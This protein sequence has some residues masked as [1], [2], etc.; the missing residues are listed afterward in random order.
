MGTRYFRQGFLAAVALILSTGC[1]STAE[2]TQVRVTSA[3]PT[4]VQALTIKVE[5]LVPDVEGEQATLLA[6]LRNELKAMGYQVDSGEIVLTATITGLD[7]GSTIANVVVGLGVGSDDIDI[8]VKLSD[9]GGSPYSTFLA[10]G[11]AVD[12]RYADMNGVVRALGKK[13][14][15]QVSQQIR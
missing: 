10:R 12:K 14:A 6:S 9:A 15:E 7:R 4:G 5:S 8:H 3:A 1:A 11:S 2:I 13:I